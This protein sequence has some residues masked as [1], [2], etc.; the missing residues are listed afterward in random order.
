MADEP[1]GNGWREHMALAHAAPRC[2]AKRRDGGRCQ[3]PAMPNGRCRL[4]GGLSTG[5]KTPEGKERARKAAWVHGHYSAES[6]A[7]RARSRRLLADLRALLG[8][9]RGRA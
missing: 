1:H 2:G 6:I 3:A 9:C 4:H 8:E 7:D 5:P